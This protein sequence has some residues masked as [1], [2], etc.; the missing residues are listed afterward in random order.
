MTEE[1]VRIIYQEEYIDQHIGCYTLNKKYHHNLYDEFHKYNLPI[2]SHTEK[3][4]K[5]FCQDDYFENIDTEEKAYW[6]G[7]LMADGFISIKGNGKRVGISLQAKDCDHIIK[8]Q[9]A[10]KTNTPI[11]TYSVTRGYKIGSMYS[12]IIVHS[13]KMIDDLISH[14]CVQQKSNILKPP[15]GVPSELNRHWIRGFMDGNGSITI[16]KNQYIDSYGI[17]FVSTDDVLLWI[18]DVLIKD[19]ILQ[20]TYPLDKRKKEQ[21]VSNFTFGGNNLVKQY[22][23]YIYKDATVYL[24]R[25]YERYIQL[26]EL[27]KQR[28]NKF[29]KHDCDICGDKNSSSYHLWTK[30]DEYNGMTV[31]QKHY[32]QLY[33]HGKIIPDRKD[34]CE[35]CGETFGKMIKCGT[36]YM[37]YYGVTMCRKHYEQI[38]THGKITDNTKGWHKNE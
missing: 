20:R 28:D 4:K 25:K 36:K 33:H 1:E 27:I 11:H 5:Y 3:N 37:D 12:R 23:D 35:I 26:T 2:R 8:F 24:D 34:Y 38:Y 10:I 16:H 31:C 14:G 32:Q 22:C 21:I 9:K 15:T 17:G 13:A 18:M 30:D 29:I 7:F 6:L 19:G